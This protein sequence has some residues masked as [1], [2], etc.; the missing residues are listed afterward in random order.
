MSELKYELSHLDESD[1]SKE[2][3]RNLKSFNESLIGQANHQGLSIIVRNREEQIVA[4]LVGRTFWE[5]LFIDILWVD[6]SLRGRSVGTKLVRDAE[7]EAFKRGCKRAL[8]DT[9]SFQA[10]GFYEKMGYQLF[11]TLEDFPTTGQKR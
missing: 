4:G 9:F 3:R 1:D 7:M 5:W 8:L 11:S 6:E 10:P 2:V